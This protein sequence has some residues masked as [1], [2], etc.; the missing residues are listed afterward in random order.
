MLLVQK[1]PHEPL[2]SVVGIIVL[3]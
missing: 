3:V 1:I 2:L